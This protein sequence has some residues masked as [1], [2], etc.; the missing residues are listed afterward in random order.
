[1]T[2]FDGIA[3]AFRKTQARATCLLSLLVFLGAVGLSGCAGIVTA[4]PEQPGASPL[5]ITV[6]SLPSGTT[7]VVYSATLTASG[8]TAPYS[9]SMSAGA[10]PPGLNMSA[11]GQITGMPT[12]AGNSSFSVQ[13]KD[14]SVPA[15]SATASLGILVK[16]SATPLVISTTSVPAGAVNSAYSATF[17]GTGGTGPYSWALA[18]GQLPPGLSLNSSSGVLA[19]TPTQAGTFAFKIDLTDSGSPVQSSVAD[20]SVSITAVNTS[21]QISTTSLP[22]GETGSAYTATLAAAGGTAP[23]SWSATAGALPTG[24]TLSAAGQISGIPSK[25][26]SFSFTVQ[27]KDS[28]SPA[29]TVTKAFTISIAAIGGPL[30]ITTLTLPDAQVNAPY[31]TTVAAIGGAKPYT[32]T[33]SAGSLPAGLTLNAASGSISGTTTQSGSFSVTIQAKDASTPQ[34]TSSKV[35]SLRV[36]AAV[37]PVQILT[38]S[39]VGGQVGSVYGAA[40]TASGGTTP[41][42]WSLSA[43]ALPNGLTLSGAGQISGTPTAAGT[44]TFTV[45]VTDASAPA[46]PATP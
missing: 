36:A 33:I 10:L 37:S 7:Q 40:V 12:K 28:S 46:K 9:W 27:A 17:T 2:L 35:L 19:G 8:A 4:N 31:A 25:N 42:S 23:Y 3:D 41:Y 21:L 1:M 5:S 16:S 11:S 34:Q 18:S 45:K 32:W 24:L 44:S 38:T 22:A 13:V 6:S 43:G 29:A 30:Q 39:L 20:F 15:K 26:G 14:S